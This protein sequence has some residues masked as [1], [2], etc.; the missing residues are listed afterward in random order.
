[1]LKKLG[2][3][4]VLLTDDQRRVLAANGHALGRKVLL[5]LTTIMTPDT[6]LP[7]HRELVAKK[8]DHSDQRKIVGRPRLR[9]VIVDSILRFAGRIRRG[10]MIAFRE[11]WPI[12]VTILLTPRWPTC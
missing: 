10:A 2:K 3:K 11:H 12:S 5:E 1:M 7:W 6:I 4:R 9:Q 8:W